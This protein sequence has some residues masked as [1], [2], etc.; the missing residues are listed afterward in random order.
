LLADALGE[1]SAHEQL[2]RLQ[3]HFGGAG[4]WSQI[5][6][7]LRSWGTAH[8]PPEAYEAL[9]SSH[10]GVLTLHRLMQ[11]AEPELLTAD[12]GPADAP[13]EAA[14]SEMVRDPRYWRRRDPD[15]VAR[16]TAGFRRLFAD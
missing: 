16:V 15:F 7:Q 11:A 8:L 5:A 1:V 9:A 10:D 12:G 6:R 3:T 2:L 13:D 14:L 4:A